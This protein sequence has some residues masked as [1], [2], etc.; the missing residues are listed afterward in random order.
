LLEALV[1]AGALNCVALLQ[2]GALG[3]LGNAAAEAEATD[4]VP[5]TPELAF[6]WWVWVVEGSVAQR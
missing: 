4:F 2:S 5:T 1:S 3:S 6:A